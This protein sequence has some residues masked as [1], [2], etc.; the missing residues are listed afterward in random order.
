MDISIN[1]LPVQVAPADSSQRLSGSRL[2]Q[3][4][5]PE[6]RQNGTTKVVKIVPLE[7][8]MT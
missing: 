5:L 1:K 7:N 3:N 2:V 4:A 8:T 6:K